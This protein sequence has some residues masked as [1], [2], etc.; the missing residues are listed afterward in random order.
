MNRALIALAG[1][2]LVAALAWI[3][4]AGDASTNASVPTASEPVAEAAPGIE[5][6]VDELQ[7]TTPPADALRSVS[8]PPPSTSLPELWTLLGPA[9][10]AGDAP[11]ACRLAIET[12]RCGIHQHTSTFPRLPTALPAGELAALEVFV[13]D[14]TGLLTEVSGPGYAQRGMTDRIERL[15][16]ELDRHCGTLATE[17]RGEALALLRQAALAG[18]PDA[19]LTYVEA[20]SGAH[21]PGA[22]ADPVFERWMKETPTVL[23]RMLDAGHPNA[24][25]LFAAAY[26]RDRFHG[27]LFPYD[28]MRSVAYGQLDRRIGNTSSLASRFVEIRR[29]ALTAA[30]RDEADR[31][32]EQLYAAHY[33]GRPRARSERQRDMLYTLYVGVGASSAARARECQPHGLGT[34]DP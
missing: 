14:P 2:L 24:P 19:Q 18:V 10:R 16:A 6:R 32:A 20:F 21:L 30:Q 22:M 23:A 27:H 3:L 17:R 5:P 25:S 11:S 34:E 7:D 8:M 15:N 28:P 31:L 4:H 33:A 12:L 9:A 13:A 1:L 26:G 29:Q